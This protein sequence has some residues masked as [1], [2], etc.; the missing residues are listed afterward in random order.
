MES[1]SHNQ[2]FM[3][4]TEFY[5]VGFPGI[6]RYRKVL[7]IPFTFI[8]VTILSGNGVIIYHVF[9]QPSL[10]SPMYV[11]MSLLFASNI[12]CA[13]TVLPKFIL[14]LSFDMEMITL[15]GCLIQM[16]FMYSLG[17]VES[18]ILL[19][20]ALDRFVAICRPLRYNTIM[21]KKLMAYL[22]V[23]GI[24]RSVLLT[25]P[26]VLLAS[27]YHFCK[28]NI[29]LNFVC[30][31][32]G[33]LSLACED[34]SRIHFVGLIIKV[35]ALLTDSSLLLISYSSI[36]YTTIKI[37]VGKARNKALQTCLTHI[38][39]ALL[40]YMCSFLVSITY[41]MRERVSYDIKNLF[42]ALYLMAP[43][44]LNPFIYGAGMKEIRS[45]ITRFWRN[46][47]ANIFI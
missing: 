25:I 10:H 26:T 28:S 9:A 38:V 8:Y 22:I 2:T 43:A 30:E 3:S 35:L 24:M 1:L 41:R 4:Y 29:I 15:A 40:L 46:K 34:I 5:L 39:V 17:G 44:S 37:I 33:L 23:I 47:D 21:T 32:M 16:F 36:L 6:I 42:T 19:I 27:R 20:M 18:A 45:C 12:A 14:G 11:L 13:T 7:I 31:N